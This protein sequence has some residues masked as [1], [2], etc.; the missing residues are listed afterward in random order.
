MTEGGG[1][2]PAAPSSK[3]RLPKF[4]KP[5]VV[6]VVFATAFEPVSLSVVDL[7]R[8]G[9]ERFGEELPIHLEQQPLQM[10]TESFDGAVQNLAPTL[11]LLTGAPPIRLW[12]QSKDR[13]RLV[14]IQRDWLAYN[15]QRSPGDDSYPRYTAIEGPFLRTWD[16]FSDFLVSEGHLPLKAR[17]CELSYINHI[18]PGELWQRPGQLKNVIRLVGDAGTFLSEPE[19]GQI[20]FRYR[21]SHEGKDIGRLYIQ[22]SPGQRR[23]DLSP[24]I[25][26]QIT[27]RGAPLGEGRE[28]VAEFFEIARQWAVNGFTAVTT[29][30][31]QNKLWGRTR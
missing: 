6:E 18:L 14:Q 21:M 29:D 28:G 23:D 27:A 25:Q 15:W 2:I 22:S 30:D 7:A 31:A 13:S 3:P 12:F 5:P 24:V 4:D 17:Q 19:D 8:F 9:L 10:A 1:S 20:A 11:A 26:L 16:E